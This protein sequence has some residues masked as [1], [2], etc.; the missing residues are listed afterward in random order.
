MSK[1]DPSAT[2]EHAQNVVLVSRHRNLRRAS[3]QA[4]RAREKPEI[5]K[6]QL[7]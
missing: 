7:F 3:E 2:R 1:R 4:R 6:Q 5:E